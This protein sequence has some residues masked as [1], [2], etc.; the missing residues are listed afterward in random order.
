MT[1]QQFLDERY[2]RRTSRRRSRAGWI[3]VAVV[4]VAATVS[5]GWS[6]VATSMS[7]VDVDATA[8]SVVDEHTVTVTFQVV[9]PSD[10]IVACALEAQDEEHGVV[11]WRVVEMSLERGRLQVFTETIPTTGEAT[12]GLVNSC[13]V[14]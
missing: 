4:A 14:A 11:G 12:T 9:A 8:Y 10:G 3:I 1:T 5:L 2:G 13:W 7:S 6:T